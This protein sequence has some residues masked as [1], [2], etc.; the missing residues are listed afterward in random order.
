MFAL[1]RHSSVVQLLLQQAPAI[2]VSIVIA[3]AFYK[4]HSFTLECLAFLATW[5]VV[6]ALFHAIR[7]FSTRLSGKTSV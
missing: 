6:D 7:Q 3:E 4:F 5:F 2:A 1:I